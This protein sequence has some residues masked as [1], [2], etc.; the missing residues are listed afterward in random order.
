TVD[1][2]YQNCKAFGGAYTRQHFFGKTPETLAMVANLSDDDIWRLNRGGH[3][4]HKVYAAYDAAVRTVGQPTVI[5]AKTVKGYGMGSAGEALNP[6][7]QT[8]KLDDDSVRAFRDRF[9]L[10]IS[11]DQLKDGAVPFFKPADKSPEMEYMRDR[12]A[13][14]GGYLPAR[15][16]KASQ[17]LEVPPLAT[18]E[19]LLKSTGER[20]I[21]TTMAFVQM[22]NMILRDKQVGP[23]CVPIVADEARTFGMEGLFRQLGIYAP[24]GQKYKPVDADQ[25]MFYRED[26][27]GQVLE[28]GITE[29]G[30]FASWM[31]L[32][33]SYSV[34]DLQMLPFYIYYSMFGFQR[35]GDFAWQA[36]DMRARGFVL[37][38]TAGR[39]TLNGEG[40]QHEDGHSHIQSGLIPNVRS[41]DPSF[42]YEVV[43]IVHY[44]MQ[45][46][47]AEQHDEY[48]YITL[49]NENYTHP[50]MPAGSEEGIIKGMYLL[51]DAG[52]S[53]KGD[54][55]VQL[56]GSGTILNEVTAAAVLLDADFGI[57]SDIWSCPSFTEL[58]RD[59]M[60]ASRWNRF[61]PEAKDARK[62]WVTQQLEGRS[63]PAIAA[64]DYVR[65][66]PDQI[67]EFVPM[68][69][70]ALGT[71]GYGRSD[72][73]ENL[74]R[75]FEVDRY[76]IAHAA[77]A[78]LAA[79]G[80]LTGKD[81][82]RA[83]KLY[84]IDTEAPN[85]LLA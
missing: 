74:R 40:L 65:A 22:F 25:L 49:M 57:K 54:L 60:D 77:V 21:S 4:P 33:T 6:T 35:V 31:A 18:F 56:L 51:R 53:K 46:M 45:R 17:P 63:G 64:T 70:T 26:A 71:D 7:H 29:A 13:A 80:K 61:H 16:R 47:L 23:R 55:R 24:Q 20:E 67:R 72:T 68:R 75:H 3:D 82:A 73:R 11:D 1:G 8:K 10:P 39:T 84:K 43:T 76:H 79:E 19:R 44:G 41:Y 66:Y 14:L 27:A 5:L 36:G 34:N 58:A 32:A 9:Q 78:A 83:L 69:Y 62:P 50:E 15:R 59:G 52:R 38:G 48:F 2:E 30:A 37:G 85:P 12:R 42:S 81:V 28:E